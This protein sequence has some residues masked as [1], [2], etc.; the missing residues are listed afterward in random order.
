MHLLNGLKHFFRRINAVEICAIWMLIFSFGTVS[1]V[2]NCLQIRRIHEKN[3]FESAVF[4]WISWCCNRQNKRHEHT[5]KRNATHSKFNGTPREKTAKWFDDSG[6]PASHSRRSHWLWVCTQQEERNGS[7]I[8]FLLREREKT[9]FRSEII[10]MTG[11]V[12]WNFFHFYFQ[13]WFCTK[14]KEKTKLNWIQKILVNTKNS[15]FGTFFLNF[16]KTLY[17]LKKNYIIYCNKHKISI[18]NSHKFEK[19]SNYCAK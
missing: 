10:I 13:H 8:F 7:L 1:W 3:T 16:D 12:K 14:F 17:F 2:A 19:N 15:F 5:V 11:W 9:L 6:T 4:E 18:L